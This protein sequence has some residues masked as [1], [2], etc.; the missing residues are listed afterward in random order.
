MDEDQ[1]WE[2]MHRGMQMQGELRKQ[3]NPIEAELP[4]PN[5]F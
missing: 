4:K 3:E 2:A 1:W 5:G